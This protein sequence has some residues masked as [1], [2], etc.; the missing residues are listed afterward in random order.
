VAVNDEAAHK[1]LIM[2]FQQ[3]KRPDLVAAEQAWV[4]DYEKRV[5][6]MK[7]LRPGSV[8]GPGPR[9]PMPLPGAPKP[10]G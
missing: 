5:A 6:E 10:G 8:P 7:K 9:A 3:L 4:A 2:K 1:Q